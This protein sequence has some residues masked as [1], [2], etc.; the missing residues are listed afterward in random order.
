MMRRKR[1]T[2]REK[3]RR[4]TRLITLPVRILNKESRMEGLLEVIIS[5]IRPNQLL[6]MSMELL[7]VE[8]HF[9]L[10]L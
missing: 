10:A 6:V 7:I 5:L 9:Q 8:T 3:I 4:R 2:R 1:R